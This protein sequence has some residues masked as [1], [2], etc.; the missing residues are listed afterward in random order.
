MKVIEG[1]IAAPNAQIAIVISRFNSFINESL[2]EGAVD[3]L[4][5]MGQVSEEN[6]TVIRVP[7]AYELPLVAKRVA[8]SDRYDAIVA[9]AL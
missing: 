8:K 3:A 6:I 9:L 4:K 2:L 5:R 1:A 7:G